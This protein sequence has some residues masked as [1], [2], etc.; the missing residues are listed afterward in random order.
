[1]YITNIAVFLTVFS[2][3]VSLLSSKIHI[4]D[5]TPK[6]LMDT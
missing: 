3:H 6:E 5:D 1:L 4:G 2:I